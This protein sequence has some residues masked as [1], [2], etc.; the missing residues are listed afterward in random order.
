MTDDELDELGTKY[1]I[2][3]ITLAVPGDLGTFYV[4]RP[5][6][7]AQLTARDAARQSNWSLVLSILSLVLSIIAV[8]VSLAFNIE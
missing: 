4:D 7:I 5:R 3:P 6:I 2:P 1:N 8:A